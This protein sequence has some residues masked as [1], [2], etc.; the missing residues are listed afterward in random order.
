MSEA[1]S[2]VQHV[3]RITNMASQLKDV[4]ENVSDATVM[5]KILASLTTRFS[6]LQ[7]AWDSV[8]PGR[9]TLDNLQERLI[10]EDTRLNGA[11]ETSEALAATAKNRRARRAKSGENKKETKE[12][13]CY[14]C[15]EMGHI[16]SRCRNKR[17]P[18][19]DN[20]KPRDCAFVGE[21][22]K[23]S[24]A[25]GSGSAGNARVLWTQSHVMAADQSEVWLIDSGA[26]RHLTYRRDWLTDYKTDR[27][28]ATISLGDNQICNVAGE[29][30][31]LIKKFI[32]GV[33]HDARIEKVLHVPKLRKNLFSVGVCTKKGLGV[34]FK[35]NRVEVVRDGEMLATGMKQGVYRMFFK[36]GN[37][38]G[39]RLTRN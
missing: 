4:G 18:R 19:V 25:S 14:K 7:V 5:A 12:V 10:R 1:D 29:G 37:R 24:V 17:K 9:Q 27:T 21:I 8:D 13:Q 20:E 30:T 6:T 32:D 28:G 26:S 15:Q 36:W 3:A 38:T 39:C 22:G 2:A 31:V 33:W 23:S 34:Q 35:N 16:A 11:E